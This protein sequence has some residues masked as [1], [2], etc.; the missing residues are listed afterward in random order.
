MG[1]WVQISYT[2]IVQELK[3]M[4]AGGFLPRK[5]Q[6][7]D[8]SRDVELEKEVMTEFVTTF[9]ERKNKAEMIG[10]EMFR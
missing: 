5:L 2:G 10:R 4:Q 1:C 9:L 3:M 8:H 6:M 7:S